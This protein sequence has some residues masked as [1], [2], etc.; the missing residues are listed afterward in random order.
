MS[1]FHMTSELDIMSIALFDFEID[2][3]T[4][5]LSNLI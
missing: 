1:D 2:H 4:G 3:K 5:L